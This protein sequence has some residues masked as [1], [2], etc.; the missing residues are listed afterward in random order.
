MVSHCCHKA[1]VLHV[2]LASLSIRTLMSVLQLENG[3]FCCIDI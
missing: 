1:V 2:L 3:R